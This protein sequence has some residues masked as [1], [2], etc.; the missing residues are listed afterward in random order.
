MHLNE[1]YSKVRPL[2]NTNKQ[3]PIQPKSVVNRLIFILQCYQN[4]INLQQT[5][6]HIHHNILAN[7][8]IYDLINT[9]LSSTYNF[10]SLLRDYW[11]V[12]QKDRGAFGYDDDDND[13]KNNAASHDGLMCDISTCFIINRNE[14]NRADIRSNDNKRNKLFFIKEKGGSP[15]D[16]SDEAIRSIMTQQILDTLHSWVYHSLKLKSTKYLKQVETKRDVEDFSILCKDDVVKKFGEIIESKKASSK[17]FRGRNNRY[18][19]KNN[20][21]ITSNNDYTTTTNATQ[22][23]IDSNNDALAIYQ[24]EVYGN[25]QLQ[26]KRNNEDKDDQEQGHCCMDELYKVIGQSEFED[27]KVIHELYEYIQDEEFESEALM[28]DIYQNDDSQS[29]ILGIFTS[30]SNDGN[31]LCNIL[32]KFIFETTLDRR[33]YSPGWRYYYWDFYKY[34]TNQWNIL[35]KDDTGRPTEEGNKGYRLMDWYIH[36]KYL[37]YKTEIL[38]N[39]TAPFDISEYN[40][41]LMTATEKRQNWLN[42]EEARS[43]KCPDNHDFFKDTYG[44][45]PGDIIKVEHIMSVMFYTNFTENSRLFSETYRKQSLYETDESL[46]QRH[47]E[48]YYWG[49]YLRECVEVFGEEMAGRP[50]IGIFYHGISTTLLFNSSSIYLFGPLSTTRGIF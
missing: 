38:N 3:S 47:S 10:Q 30:K 8:T 32:I 37:T 43:L 28:Q 15:S 14:M 42:N 46:K 36:K 23:T 24:A 31:S 20:K 6:S 2:F 18:T 40:D 26:L 12:T 1:E 4:W 21:F 25:D 41:V 5:Q 13:E 39:N 33:I 44:I 49:R 27:T 34:N 19:K 16:S 50:D 35:Y 11:H 7:L 48:L 22:K 9:Y 45:A 17:R 29:N